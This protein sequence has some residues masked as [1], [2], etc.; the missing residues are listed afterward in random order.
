MWDPPA[1]DEK[2][3]VFVSG[4]RCGVSGK[5]G[6]QSAEKKSKRWWKKLELV[7]SS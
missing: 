4:M 6:F 2:L 5:D 3:E 1:T 7:P